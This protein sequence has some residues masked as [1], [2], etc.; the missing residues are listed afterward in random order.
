[1]MRIGNLSLCLLS[2]LSFL[3]FAAEKRFQAGATTGYQGPYLWVSFKVLDPL[4]GK[5]VGT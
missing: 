5:A 2:A 4:R 1:M 3:S